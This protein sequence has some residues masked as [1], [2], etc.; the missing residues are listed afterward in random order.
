[1]VRLI[2]WNLVSLDGLFEGPGSD[3]SFMQYAWGPELEL[4]IHAQAS[5]FGTLV[6]GRKTYVGMAEFW[7]DKT[8][9]IGQIMNET[10]KVVFSNTL[11]KAE[12]PPAR[13]ARGD[14]RTEVERIKRGSRKDAYVLGSANLCAQL[15]RENLID[16]YRVGLVS[17]LVGGGRP[18][19]SDIASR[20]PLRLVES[21]PLGDKIT[22]LRYE[23]P[24]TK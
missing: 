18:M 23:P 7:A 11:A 1:M 17:M 10:P 24:A 9:F 21:R 19:F 8:D 16:E 3:L 22:L 4:F 13:V 20:I 14:L 6:F 5:L 15:A 12:W 2:M